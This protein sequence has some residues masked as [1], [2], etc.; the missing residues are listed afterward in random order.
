MIMLTTMACMCMCMSSGMMTGRALAIVKRPL[1]CCAQSDLARNPNNQ[2]F[3]HSRQYKQRPADWRE[4]ALELKRS[5]RMT[6]DANAAAS[7]MKPKEQ[8]IGKVMRAVQLSA[9][10][11]LGPKTLVL[12]A[13]S[14]KKHTDIAT[15]DLDIYL[16]MAD[17]M[18]GKQKGELTENLRKNVG[19]RVRK[20]QERP[21]S[22]KLFGANGM[23]VDIVPSKSTFRDPVKMP[24]PPPKAQFHNNPKAQVAVRTLKQYSEQ[25]KKQWQGRIIE[26]AVLEAQHAKAGQNAAELHDSALKKLRPQA[27]SRQDAVRPQ[28]TVRQPE[29]ARQQAAAQAKATEAKRRR[30][31]AA[32][33]ERRREFRGVHCAFSISNAHATDDLAGRAFSLKTVTHLTLVGEGFFMARENCGSFWT[34]L[35]AALHSRLVNEGLNTQGAVKYVAAGPDGQYYADVGS[36]IW[37]SV[38]CSD[39]FDEVMEEADSSISR[40]AF[41]PQGSWIILYSDG[42]S[43]WE[44]IPTGLHNKLRSRN[45]RLSKPV[46]V[47]LGQNETWYVKFADGTYDYCL[48]S[49]VAREFEEWQEAGWQVSN[50]LLN[51]ANGDWLL[52]YS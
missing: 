26:R 42:E 25:H 4:K 7:T 5:G 32:E 52:R 27:V 14:L 24:T 19:K 39:S 45:P 33:L 16:E 18:T 49:E 3:W 12:K 23:T 8:F 10:Q 35:P 9:K 36:S 13:G 11:V 28:E 21:K 20:V 31:A 50:V 40:V 6:A 37:W 44:G 29:A 34:G 1:V 22:I 30:K 43:A 46:E 48:P 15:S 38:T 41:G 17:P 51:S 2:A 47:A